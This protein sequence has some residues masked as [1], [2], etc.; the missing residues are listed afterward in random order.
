[1]KMLETEQEAHRAERVLVS[2]L[3]DVI[4]MHRAEK[5]R[6]MIYC[7]CYCAAITV[8]AIWGWLR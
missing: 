4:Q 5:R 7:A 1:M 6:L 8:A 2:D 3:I